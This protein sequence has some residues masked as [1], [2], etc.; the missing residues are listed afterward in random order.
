M[1]NDV[2]ELKQYAAV[3]ARSLAIPRYQRL[4]DAIRA[5][6][7]LADSWT[8]EWCRAGEVFEQQGRYLQACSHFAMGRFPYPNGPARRQAQERC[9]GAFDRWRSGRPIERLDIA[10][11]GG[12]IRCWASG[13]SAAGRLPVLL[14]MG[15]IVTVKEQHAAMLANIGRLGM[16]GV[17]TEMPGVG[18]NTLAYTADSWQMISSLLDVLTDR[19]DTSRTYA[20]ALSFSGH[21]ALRCAVADPRI[22]GIIT[23]GAP[24]SEFF[25]SVGRP[26]GIPRIT[27]DTL[28][29]LTGIDAEKLP[30]QLSD[31]ALTDRELAGLSI[32]V[33]YMA[34]LRDEIVPPGEVRRLREHVRNLVVKEQDDEHGSPRHVAET[35]LWAISSLLRMRGIHNVSSVTVGALSQ[36]ARF[37]GKIA[38]IRRR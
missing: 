3:H 24:V 33:A 37:W 30:G 6:D 19:A 13:L 25:T 35:K 4:L 22:K 34:S 18:E 2:G 8:R 38:D 31:W 23:A 16:A 28:A 36:A 1:Q 17:V 27:A 26:H 10:V 12:R 20:L 29:H 5:D 32:P 14:V 11:P 21:M 9:V 7:D 15:G